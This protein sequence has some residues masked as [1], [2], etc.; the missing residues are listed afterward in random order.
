MKIH[1]DQTFCVNDDELNGVLKGIAL[2]E[3]TT[4]SVQTVQNDMMIIDL[5]EKGIIEAEKLILEFKLPELERVDYSDNSPSVYYCSRN[6]EHGKEIMDLFAQAGFGI[7]NYS[8][9]KKNIGENE[10][11]HIK[12]SLKR[13]ELS[14]FIQHHNA[15]S[16]QDPRLIELMLLALEYDNV[17]TTQY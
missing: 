17:I 2:K 14:Y 1:K 15:I 12:D 11:I 3:F 6:Y 16:N 4:N 5:S 13:G 10:L 7:I 9:K 8:D